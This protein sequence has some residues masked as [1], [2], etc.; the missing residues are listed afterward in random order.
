MNIGS[1][2][3]RNRATVRC[4]DASLVWRVRRDPTAAHTIAIVNSIECPT[5]TKAYR[6]HCYRVCITSLFSFYIMSNIN[7]GSHTR[8]AMS[9]VDFYRRVPKDLTEVSEHHCIGVA[10]VLCLPPFSSVCTAFPSTKCTMGV[11]QCPKIC[12]RIHW[13]IFLGSYP[14]T[15]MMLLLLLIATTLICYVLFYSPHHTLLLLG[16]Y[17]WRRHVDVCHWNHVDFVFE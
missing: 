9:S 16:H 7:G 5:R 12:E 17:S 13:G 4:A 14:F 11:T 1:W 3:S 10:F 15:M 8:N 6:T 2:G